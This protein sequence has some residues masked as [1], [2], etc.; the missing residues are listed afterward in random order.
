MAQPKVDVAQ[1]GESTRS[2]L[3]DKVPQARIYRVWNVAEYGNA[4]LDRLQ[5]LAQVLGGS[6]ASRLDKRLA[7]GDKLVDSISAAAYGSQLGSNFL[8]VADVKQGVDVA[9]VEAAIDEELKKLLADG[10]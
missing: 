10:P 4:D 6:K 2:T 5:L 7:H 1:R 9:K 8:I 3:E